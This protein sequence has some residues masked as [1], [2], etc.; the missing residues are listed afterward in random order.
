MDS[1]TQNS[2]K[3]KPV[4]TFISFGDVRAAGIRAVSALLKDRGWASNIII[5]SRILKRTI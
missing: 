3:S 1:N 5:L 4:T 2:Q